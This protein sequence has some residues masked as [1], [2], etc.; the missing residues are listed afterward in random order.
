MA[1]IL[2]IDDN[3]DMLTMLQMLLER[4]GNH[5][6]ITSN[7]GMDGL[8]KANSELPDIMI[9]DVMM[10]GMNGYDVVNQLRADSRT[11]SIPIIILTARGQPVDRNA[12]FEAGANSHLAK[13]VDIQVLLTTIDNLLEMGSYA[14]LPERLVVPVLSLRGGVGVTTIAV[15]LAIL[16]QQI[17]P[18]ILWDLS[19]S[20]GH[21]ALSLGLQPNLN[22]RHFLYS[23]EEPVSDILLKHPS[24]LRLLAA[25]PVPEINN[26]FNPKTIL[27]LH[28]NLLQLGSIIV[29]DMPSFL[30]NATVELLRDAH[31]ILLVSCDDNPGIQ[32]TLAT[33]QS[34]KVLVDKTDQEDW[35]TVIRNSPTSLPRK[36]I[37]IFQRSIGQ[38]IISDIPFDDGQNNAFQRGIPLAVSNPTSPLVHRLKHL[39]QLLLK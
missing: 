26:W 5:E 36:H 22:W 1:R 8:E 3:D 14:N 13:P 25:P 20:S 16:M 24:G 6:V 23:P 31:H 32:T 12:A 19:P 10:P 4:R 27:N 7:N 33:M 34:L 35:P 11:K 28:A 39:A 15:N 18:T 9:V 30:D 38:T 17:A 2:V 21:G 37:D 29:I